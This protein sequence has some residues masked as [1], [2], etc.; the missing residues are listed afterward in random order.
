[1]NDIVLFSH[2]FE[3]KLTVLRGNRQL[4]PPQLLSHQTTI[5]FYDASA[6][7][8]FSANIALTAKPLDMHFLKMSLKTTTVKAF[9]HVIFAFVS[10]HLNERCGVK[11]SLLLMRRF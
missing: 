3:A 8:T 1:M 6:F 7:A 11:V 9:V 5:I 2:D 10:K 4:W